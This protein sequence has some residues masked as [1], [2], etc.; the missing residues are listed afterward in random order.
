MGV[1]GLLDGCG[2]C[3]LRVFCDCL[4]VVCD[5]FAGWLVCYGCW[6]ARHLGVL[7]CVLD[8]AS[9]LLG[10]VGLIDVWLGLF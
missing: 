6:T 7:G 8:C 9:C 5:W 10:L 3:R 1:W 4:F 2:G